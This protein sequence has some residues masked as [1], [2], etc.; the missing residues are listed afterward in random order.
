MYQ[1]TMDALGI[2]GSNVQTSWDYHSEIIW[3]VECVVCAQKIS[4]QITINTAVS[5]CYPLHFS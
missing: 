5:E 2:I 1:I 4:W 3:F